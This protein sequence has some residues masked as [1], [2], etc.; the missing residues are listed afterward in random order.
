M[1][2]LFLILLSLLT[3]L[4]C[5]ARSPTKIAAPAKES[6][7]AAPTATEPSD[8]NKSEDEEFVEGHAR[9]LSHLSEGL[10]PHSRQKLASGMP[11]QVRIRPVNLVATTARDDRATSE[12]RIIFDLWEDAYRV[13][14]P[15][16]IP[17]A[18]YPT[19]DEALRACSGL[20]SPP[21]DT[22]VSFVVEIN[23][24]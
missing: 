12:C 7:P 19:L 24:P 6:P 1:R 21:R 5:G 15:S 2:K 14:T 20:R 4:G 9:S 10:T 8:A 16:D 3:L 18:R 11:I 13:R 23:P 17:G 22:N